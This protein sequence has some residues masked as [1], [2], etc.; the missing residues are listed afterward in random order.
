MTYILL[1]ETAI[2]PVT[3]EAIDGIMIALSG[4]APAKGAFNALVDLRHPRACLQLLS[5][6]ESP[7]P[8]VYVS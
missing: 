1:E 8:L 6:I 3:T 7:P 4:I 5:A 2:F